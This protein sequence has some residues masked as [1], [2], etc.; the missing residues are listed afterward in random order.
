MSGLDNYFI[1]DDVRPDSMDIVGTSL[2]TDF[3][4]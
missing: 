1:T 4:L 3:V 2:A